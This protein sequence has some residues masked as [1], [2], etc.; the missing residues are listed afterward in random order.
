M[1]VLIEGQMQSSLIFKASAL[2]FPPL[3][4]EAEE[5]EAAGAGEDAAEQGDRIAFFSDL[6]LEDPDCLKK[7]SKEQGEAQPTWSRARCRRWVW[8]ERMTQLKVL[9]PHRQWL[10]AARRRR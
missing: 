4:E 6:T 7:F 9:A 1:V 5:T 3:D 2:I 8:S 10:Q